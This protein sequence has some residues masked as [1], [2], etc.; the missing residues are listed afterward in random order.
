M[1]FDD[2]LTM[3][4]ASLR[5]GRE[6]G[7]K[8]LTVAVLDEGGCL[9]VLHRQDDT[10]ILRP[11]IAI[12]KAW[13]ALGMGL[14]TRTLAQL[15]DERPQFFVALSVLAQGKVVPV[16]GGVLVRDSDGTLMG[17]VGITGDTSDNDEACGIAGVRAANLVPDTGS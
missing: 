15:A 1:R 2:A 14:P 10:G 5:K 7:C 9:K 13:G 16:P 6:L 11:D 8:P 17:A 12:A 4:D 3:A